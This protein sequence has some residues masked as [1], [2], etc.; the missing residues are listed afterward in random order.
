MLS[1]AVLLGGGI[2]GYASFASA[3]T[4]N[5]TPNFTM[6]QRAPHVGGT[7]TA[8][9]GSTIT[10]ASGLNLGGATY[11]IDASSAV[12]M[13]SGTTS[14]VSAFAVGDRIF[15]EGTI[16]GTNVTATKIFDGM[17]GKGFG[18][19]GKG[20]GGMRQGVM[21]TVTS[22]NGTT[23]TLT[24]KD[25]KTY[26]VDAG[27]ATVQKMTTESLSNVMVG[28]TIGVHGTVSGT[29]VKATNIMDDVQLPQ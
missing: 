6:Q 13:K 1:A 18:M 29:S 19:Q 28:D 3:Q 24:G 5:P 17:G 23:V 16:N 15:A 25:G 9:N 26:T 2:A 7:I 8:I 20:R 12:V 11:T 14:T 10:I 22:V 21:G 27:T 4:A